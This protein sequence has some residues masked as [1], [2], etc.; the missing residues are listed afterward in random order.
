MHLETIPFYNSAYGIVHAYVNSKDKE[1]NLNGIKMP[2]T[3]E[4]VKKIKSYSKTL[5][6]ELPSYTRCIKVMCSCSKIFS[7]EEEQ[8]L[9]KKVIEELDTLPVKPKPAPKKKKN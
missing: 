8:E 6:E 5:Y 1:I 7:K 4:R 2:F 9:K 3:V